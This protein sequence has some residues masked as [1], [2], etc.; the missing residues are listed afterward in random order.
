[1]T[2]KSSLGQ[3]TFFKFRNY[4]VLFILLI[5]KKL[6]AELKQLSFIQFILLI[7]KKLNAVLK[8]L[9]IQ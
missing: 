5:I 2:D 4:F 9:F 1:M 6:N 7:I 8:Q 3:K